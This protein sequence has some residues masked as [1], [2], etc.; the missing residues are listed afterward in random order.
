VNALKLIKARFGAFSKYINKKYQPDLTTT[1]QWT[2]LYR[3]YEVA[4]IAGSSS[5]RI[6][7]MRYG[8]CP[9][10]SKPCQDEVRRQIF[11]KRGFRTGTNA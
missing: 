1:A 11:Q 10:D 7:L 8:F 3:A 2:R 9:H 5:A 4:R 6:D